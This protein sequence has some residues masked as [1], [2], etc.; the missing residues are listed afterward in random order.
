MYYIILRNTWYFYIYFLIHDNNKCPFT[1]TL[2]YEIIFWVLQVIKGQRLALRTRGILTFLLSVSL[3]LHL[4]VNE[5]K[6]LSKQ[7][8]QNETEFIIQINIE[9][10]QYN[11]F[12]I[13][14]ITQKA[15][16]RDCKLFLQWYMFAF[17]INF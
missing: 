14:I 17:Q 5:F 1:E 16:I 8:I 13:D 3:P 12:I 4:Y 6:L 10:C 9:A 11:T 2:C 7:Q 15:A